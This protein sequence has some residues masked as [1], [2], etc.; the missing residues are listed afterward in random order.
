MQVT[1]A[2]IAS[3]FF[4]FWYYKLETHAVDWAWYRFFF[5]F[6]LSI[7]LAATLINFWRA[8]ITI[9]RQGFYCFIGKFRQ[10]LLFAGPICCFSWVITVIVCGEHLGSRALW[11]YGRALFCQVAVHLKSPPPEPLLWLFAKD[12]IVS[13]EWWSET[14]AFAPTQKELDFSRKVKR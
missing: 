2:Y 8:V 13:G 14:R 11:E 5:F 6:P 7:V 10:Y 4:W 12:W 1:S 3:V 9:L